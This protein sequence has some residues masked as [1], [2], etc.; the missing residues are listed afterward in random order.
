M[1]IEILYKEFYIYGESIN[2]DYLKKVFSNANFIETKYHDKPFFVDNDVDIVF[3]G[4]MHEVNLNKVCKKLIPFKDDLL[5]YINKGKMLIAIN[6]ALDILGSELEIIGLYEENNTLGLFPYKTVRNYNERISELFI[7]KYNDI[8]VIGERLG[9]SQY[10]PKENFENI[11]KSLTGNM[12]NNDTRLGGL[13]YKNAFLIESLGGLFITNP[14]I[15]KRLM[16]YF[17]IEKELPHSEQVIK[18]YEYKLEIMMRDKKL[19][20]NYEE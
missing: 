9:F 4:P 16:K 13:R 15:T 3:M 5:N 12:L 20:K 10:F 19:R 1:N 7:G 17:N 8:K 14:Y 18:A 2:V 11:Y 6:N